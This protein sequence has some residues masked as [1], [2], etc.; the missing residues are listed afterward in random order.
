MTRK[1]FNWSPSLCGVLNNLMFDTYS[2]VA[3]MTKFFI[4]K[5]ITN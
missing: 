4:F 3:A 5:E 1:K 2:N